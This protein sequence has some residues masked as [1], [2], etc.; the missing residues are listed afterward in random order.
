MLPNQGGPVAENS[1]KK[2]PAAPTDP[3]WVKTFGER[4]KEL[5]QAYGASHPPGLPPGTTGPFPAELQGADQFPGG[6]IFVFPPETMTRVPGTPRRKHWLYATL[7]LSQPLTEADVGGGAKGATAD[8]P[9]PSRLGFEFGIATN[10]PADWAPQLLLDLAKL[11]LRP[12]APITIGTRIPGHFAH[13]PGKKGDQGLVPVLSQMPQGLEYWG[14]PT[15][16]LIWPALDRPGPFVTSTGR[17]DLLIA[18]G[19]TQEEWELAKATSSLHALF[20]LITAGIGQKTAPLR[21]TVLED[22][23]WKAE[24]E[25]IQPM[26]R[27]Q[28]LDKVYGTA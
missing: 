23:K 11:A 21:M 24:W 2:P 26:T 5:T 25:K 4:K 27:D 7:G 16:F 20:L 3:W 22:P 28:I 8:S 12:P 10:E 9:P 18:T 1:P 14:S 17:F 19:I 6:Q 15:S 13:P